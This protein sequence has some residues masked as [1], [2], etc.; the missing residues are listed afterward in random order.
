[1]YSFGHPGASSDD[2][3]MAGKSLSLG[4]A[5]LQIV[6]VGGL[7]QEQLRVES[8]LGNTY[9]NVVPAPELTPC[10]PNILSLLTTGLLVWNRRRSNAA[11]S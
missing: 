7:D 11:H 4:T 9:A 3:V 6:G 10:A 2:I 1:M 8:L 5:E